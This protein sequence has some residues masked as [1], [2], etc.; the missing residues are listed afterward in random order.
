MNNDFTKIARY[1]LHSIKYSLGEIYI[2]AN[3][4][5]LQMDFGKVKHTIETLITNHC[6]LGNAYKSHGSRS[7]AHFDISCITTKTWPLLRT[8]IDKMAILAE[9]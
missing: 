4:K 5:I 1:I 6:T 9:L 7:I 8:R 2:T 3:H